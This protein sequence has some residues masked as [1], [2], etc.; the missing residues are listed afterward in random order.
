MYKVVLVDDEETILNGL[1]TVVE[2]AKY[3]CEVVACEISGQAGIDAVRAHSADLL[4]TDIRMPHMDG[5]EMVTTLRTEFPKLQ[6]AVLTAFA[7][8]DYAQL[9]IK[10]GVSRYLLKPSKMDELY[11]AITAM[12]GNLDSG[13]EPDKDA[14]IN[15]VDS[16]VARNA[17]A[18]IRDHYTER[19]TLQD[20]A[21]NT[22]VSQW[23]LSKLLKKHAGENFVDIL[24][25]TRIAAAKKLLEDPS[26]RVHEVAER[27]GY[28]DVAH[29][30]KVFKR[31][32]GVSAGEYRN[33][34]LN[35]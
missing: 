7:D 19:V 24:H 6:I 5:L 4:F 18:Y 21:D 17:L 2:W 25:N 10:A 15:R 32:V 31:V 9:A 8:F 26:L 12:V 33:K 16:F 27:V 28:T 23:H 20:V 22:Y 29:F 34:H 30:S 14:E 1:K 35:S 3:G 11:E 13:E